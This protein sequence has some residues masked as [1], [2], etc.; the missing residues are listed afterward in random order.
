TQLMCHLFSYTD[1][2]ADMQF[3][4][5]KEVVNRL[6]AG[7]NSK[8]YDRLSVMEQ[9][10]CQV[11]PVLEVQPSAYTPQPKVESAVVSLVPH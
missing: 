1:A 6:V 3:M 7:P 2:F 11:S 10:Y 5:L 8:E 9:Y 4:L